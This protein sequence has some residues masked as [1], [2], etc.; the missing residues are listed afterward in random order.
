MVAHFVDIIVII[1][2]HCL[3]SIQWSYLTNSS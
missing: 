2:H 3:T 1:D